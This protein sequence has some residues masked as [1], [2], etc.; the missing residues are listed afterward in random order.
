[1]FAPTLATLEPLARQFNPLI[2]IPDR[3][4]GCGSSSAQFILRLLALMVLCSLNA[5]M[6]FFQ[7][8]PM[9]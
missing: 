4:F 5:T 1:M 3:F 2:M 8:V 6:I 9:G 7:L